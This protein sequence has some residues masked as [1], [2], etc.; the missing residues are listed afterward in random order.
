MFTSLA[1]PSTSEDAIGRVVFD[2]D[3]ESFVQEGPFQ[4][5]ELPPYFGEPPE[6]SS[7]GYLEPV[8]LAMF[9]FKLGFR[10]PFSSA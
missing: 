9:L 2:V 6:N 7:T 3:S 8:T 10:A 1:R 4:D 5:E